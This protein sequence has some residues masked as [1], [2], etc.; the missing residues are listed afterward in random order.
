MNI[1]YFENNSI[2]LSDNM[3]ALAKLQAKFRGDRAREV[4]IKRAKEGASVVCP[5]VALLP[6]IM[7]DLDTF[8]TI[9]ISDIFYDLGSG[10]GRVCVDVA[11]KYGCQCV[12]IEIDAVLCN[13][14]NRLVEESDVRDKV[15]IICDDILNQSLEEATILF[16]ALVP[17]CL[18]SLTP[19]LKDMIE[20]G[21]RIVSYK[22]PLPESE[23]WV[24]VRTLETDDVIKEGNRVYLYYYE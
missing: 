2:D 13:T 19:T 1:S 17:S 24:P 11:K 22:F 18:M 6:S 4:H 5:Y 12:G 7:T 3:S 10:D 9:S 21:K 8:V 16:I 14:A 15:S 20:K 23:G